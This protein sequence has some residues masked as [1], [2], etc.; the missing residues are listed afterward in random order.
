VTAPNYGIDSQSAD[1]MLQG[2]AY[3]EAA[4]RQ[5]R[6]ALDALASR[7]AI[8]GL[9]GLVEALLVN[10]QAHTGMPP[11]LALAAM[12]GVYTAVRDQS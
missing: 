9:I 1:V 5:D 4:K 12:R 3:F 10:N 7:D 11:S 2:I 6:E 8:V